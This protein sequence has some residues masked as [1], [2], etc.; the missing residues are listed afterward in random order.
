MTLR[1]LTA[2]LRALLWAGPRASLA[3]FCVLAGATA[4]V[5]GLTGTATTTVK[6]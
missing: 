3:V 2:A 4:T 6:A 1:S 5:A